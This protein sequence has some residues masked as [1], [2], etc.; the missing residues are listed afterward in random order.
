[1]P[2]MLGFWSQH[3]DRVQWQ[4]SMLKEVRSLMLKEVREGYSIGKNL[5][6]GRSY[7]SVSLI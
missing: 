4:S 1:M 5:R 2:R 6:C 3:R 7:R